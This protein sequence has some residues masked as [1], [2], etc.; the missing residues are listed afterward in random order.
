MINLIKSS[1][2]ICFILVFNDLTAQNANHSSIA[3]VKIMY[4]SVPQTTNSIVSTNLVMKVIPEST[5]TLVANANVSKIYVRVINE[6]LND[7]IFNANYLISSA[8]VFNVAGKKLFENNN[9][10]I[11]ISTGTIV[12]LKS[13]LFQVFTEDNQQVKSTLFSS[14]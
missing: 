9:G 10:S 4:K 12:P 13:Y 5:V 3:D 1:V 11:F 14:K 6:A 7:T 2:I 8:P